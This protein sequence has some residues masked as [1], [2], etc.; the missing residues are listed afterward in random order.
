[1]TEQPKPAN[2]ATAE[3]LRRAEGLDALDAI[4]PFDPRDRLA[5]LLTDD[6]VATLKHLASEGM[7]D[8]TLKALAS[9]LGYL[10]AWRTLATSKPLPWPAP[11]SLLL[12]FV[13]H[14]LWDQVKRQE[15]PAHDMPQKVEDGRHRRRFGG[16]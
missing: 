4:L 12:K 6:D 2:V 8:N 5:E 1:V 14:R 13:A 16:G 10:E 9:D 7:G 11:E 15:N 3:L